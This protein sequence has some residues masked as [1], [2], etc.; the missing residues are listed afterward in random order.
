MAFTR[1][2]ISL[3]EDALALTDRDVDPAVQPEQ[4]ILWVNQELRKVW[5]LI[6]RMNRDEVTKVSAQFSILSGS[7]FSISSS[8]AGNAAITDFLDFRGL[9]VNTGTLT[10][11]SW[12]PLSVWRFSDRG[13]PSRL[14][15][16]VRGDTVEIM[17]A[18]M[19]LTYPY[20]VWYIYDPASLPDEADAISLPMGADEYIAHGVAARI[21]VR[22]EEDPILHFGMQKAALEV[23]QR[24]L[25][26]HGQGAPPVVKEASPYGGSGD[27][28]GRW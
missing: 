23:M 12:L 14:S 16:R 5:A 13:A 3:V 17:P 21:R 2:R 24:W 19:A 6:A 7:T 18:T 1:T 27:T 20:R 9:D 4:L 8:A 25:S 11:P 15:Y 26:T 28:R 10:S 22:F